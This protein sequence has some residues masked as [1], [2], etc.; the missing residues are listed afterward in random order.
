MKKKIPIL[1]ILLMLLILS[2]VFS[3]VAVRGVLAKYV[4]EMET[5]PIP[6]V[7]MDF[8]FECDYANNNLYLV[9]SG[10][11]FVFNVRNFQLIDGQH[12]ISGGNIY[13]SVKVLQVTEHTENV[14][15]SAESILDSNILTNP[16]GDVEGFTV[17][18]NKFSVGSTYVVR[19]ESTLPFYKKIEFRLSVVD[20]QAENYYTMEMKESG[21]WVQIDIYIGSIPVDVT[22]NYDGFSPDNTNE[23]MKD[24]LSSSS[25]NQLT[26]LEP[27][28]RYTLIFFGTGDVK[29]VEKSP[30]PSIITIQ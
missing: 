26:D 28:T 21:N 8:Y 3:V 19:I 10:E 2:T 23:L 13:Y 11:D 24:W 27:Y 29:K 4:S 20:L 30:L 7:P 12:F 9:K 17:A 25:Q 16:Y 18:A 22:I 14:I 6:V 1:R 15:Y 5:D